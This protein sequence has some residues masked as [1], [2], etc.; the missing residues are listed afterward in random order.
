M[1][2]T[3]LLIVIA[4]LFM[5]SPANAFI[6]KSKSYKVESD[7]G[8]LGPS[9]LVVFLTAFRLKSE[10]ASFHVPFSSIDYVHVEGL[11]IKVSVRGKMMTIMA[12][13]KAYAEKISDDLTR[14]MAGEFS[15]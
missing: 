13:S 8:I 5:S 6:G 12:K 1:K 2:K 15:D 14:A 11:A 7:Y 3:S 4:I 9:K 10:D